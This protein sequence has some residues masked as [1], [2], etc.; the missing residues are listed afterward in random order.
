MS[1]G[2][3]SSSGNALWYGLD[4]PSSIPGDGGDGDFSSLHVQTGPGVHSTSC[5]MSTGVKVA[6]LES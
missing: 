5:K 4:G 1:Y 2:P 6:F 3:G